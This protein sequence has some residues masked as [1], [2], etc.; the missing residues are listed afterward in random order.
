MASRA[1]DSFYRTRPH[2]ELKISPMRAMFGWEPRALFVDGIPS[3]L[4]SSLWVD[5]V[6]DKAARVHDYLT[7]VVAE[8][9]PAPVV[10]SPSCPDVV[11]DR[12]LLRNPDRRQK[13]QP[14]FDSGWS[15]KHVIG[16]ASVVICRVHPESGRRQEKVVNAELLKRDVG[17]VVP[18]VPCASLV[19]PPDVGD[20]RVDGPR[21]DGDDDGWVCLDI[22][23]PPPHLI[24][25]LVVIHYVPVV[26]CSPLLA[27]ARHLPSLLYIITCMPHP[28]L[29]GGGVKGNYGLRI[30]MTTLCMHL[31]LLFTIC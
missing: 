17:L 30:L 18:D 12:V 26:L 13:R 28:M 2:S 22:P 15:V 5:G 10:E 20:V 16:P 9:A 21:D 19:S 24:I 8:H 6:C 31:Q 25:W 1:R 27:I 7:A 29:S 11:G 4:S 3:T 14:P 23:P